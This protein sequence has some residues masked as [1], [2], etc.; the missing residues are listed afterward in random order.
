MIC[1][2]LEV[3]EKDDQELSSISKLSLSPG[4]DIVYQW[5]DS[6]S[7]Y[8][9]RKR[10]VPKTDRTVE[11]DPEATRVQASLE[12]GVW[13]LSP[14]V[15][16]K[17]LWWCEDSTTDAE[18]IKFINKNIPSVPVSPP[19]NFLLRIGIDTLADRGAHV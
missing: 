18:T 19:Y 13:N 11:G 2:K 16:C 5:E 1:E 10:A 8:C 4:N 12:S 14:N 17:T 6:G 7:T 9:L 3:E 15:F